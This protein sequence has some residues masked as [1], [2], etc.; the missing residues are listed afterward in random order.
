MVR[1]IF[2]TYTPATASLTNYATTV[3]GASW[4]IT[5]HNT[6]DGLAHQVTLHNNTATDHSA[7]TVIYVGTNQ[8]GAAQTETINMPAGN[9]TVTSTLYYKTLISATPSL[10]I[11]ADTMGIG[12]AAT[13]SGRTIPLDWRGSLSFVSTYPTGTINTTVQYTGDNI[14]GG[15]NTPPASR[16]YKWQSDVGSPL[17]GATAPA[18]DTFSSTPLAA[19]LI[20][21]SY[22]PGAIVEL[23]ISQMNPQD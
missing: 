23:T 7:K 3:T 20:A 18:S 9:A 17:V 1:P 11:G 6:T 4:P 22:S 19:R 13:F 12:S 5:T 2:E 14:Q 8:D 15:C 16:P 10:T 21:N